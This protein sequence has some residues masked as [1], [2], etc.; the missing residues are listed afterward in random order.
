LDSAIN[1]TQAAEAANHFNLSSTIIAAST[2]SIPSRQP[3]QLHCFSEKPGRAAVSR[4]SLGSIHV[5]K[6]RP[7][8]L[9]LRH[10][11]EGRHLSTTNMEN[12]RSLTPLALSVALLLSARGVSAHGGH[13]E[14]IQEGE[15]MSADP[16]VG[17]MATRSSRNADRS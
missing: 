10:S 12:F 1:A 16:I 13:M 8:R 4:I 3:R 17:A 9:A 2:F 5:S 15:Y 14:K 6:H 11:G 7:I